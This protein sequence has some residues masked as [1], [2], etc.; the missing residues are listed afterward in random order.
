[1][2]IELRK[3]SKNDGIDIYN[4]M[5]SFDANENGFM[6]PIFGMNY[7]EYKSWLLTGLN[8]SKGIGLENGFVPQTIYWLFIND[9]PVGAGKLRD[10]LTESLRKHGGHIGYGIISSERKKGYG[11]IMLKELLKKAG[12]KN[13][14][15]VLVT[16]SKDNFASRKIIEN[17][18]GKMECETNEKCL[19]WIKVQ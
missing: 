10:Y 15:D 3:L 13:I 18:N 4:M 7:E 2:K 1:M 9:T 14:N 19:Y 16:C 5:S 6:N 12:E 17:N 8:Q 11:N